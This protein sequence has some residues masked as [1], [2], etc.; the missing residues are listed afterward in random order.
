MSS[1]SR[2]GPRELQC[3]VLRQIRAHAQ[4][5][6]MMSHQGLDLAG[7]WWSGCKEI[8][9]CGLRQCSACQLREPCRKWLDEEGHGPGYPSLCP[10]GAI[11]DR[12]LAE[13]H[14]R[15]AAA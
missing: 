14:K 6:R 8:V 15:G 1:I 9:F 5:R 3:R 13:A 2:C 10:N 11:F 4:F 12:L 7:S